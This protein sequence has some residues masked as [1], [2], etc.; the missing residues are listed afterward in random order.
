MYSFLRN[1]SFAVVLF[2]ALNWAL[3][4]LF[5]LDI[6]GYFFG[7]MSP[8]SRVIYGLFGLSAIICAI[9]MYTYHDEECCSCNPCDSCKY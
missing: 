3:Q 4:G 5:G 2:G 7:V 9:T 6:I 1:A 8:V